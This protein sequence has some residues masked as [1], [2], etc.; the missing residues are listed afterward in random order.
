MGP[1]Y[2]TILSKRFFQEMV[3]YFYHF[4]NCWYE[5]WTKSIEIQLKMIVKRNSHFN[6]PLLK[7]FIWKALQNKEVIQSLLKDSFQYSHKNDHETIKSI[8]QVLFWEAYDKVI[9]HSNV[10]FVKKINLRSQIL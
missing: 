3:A 10:N 8:K 2:L 1:D 4:P 7:T 6:V 9:N 5:N